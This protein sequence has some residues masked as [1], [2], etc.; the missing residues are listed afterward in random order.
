MITRDVAPTL[1]IYTSVRA[2]IRDEVGGYSA[3]ADYW[4]RCLYEGER[5]DPEDVEK[6]FLKS[7]LL[8]KVC[9]NLYNHSLS[10]SRR[11]LIGRLLLVDLQ[12]YI[13]IAIFSGR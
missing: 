2:K 9:D 1:T 4:I 8:V 5:G 7:G 13:H 12:I 3:S 11:L 10:V 6:G